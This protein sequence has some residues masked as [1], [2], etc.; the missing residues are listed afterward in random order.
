MNDSKVIKD[1]TVVEKTIPFADIMYD[2]NVLPNITPIGNNILVKGVMVEFKSM[3]LLAKEERGIIADYFEV[4]KIGDMV[5]SKFLN[6][7]IILDSYI[8][9]TKVQKAIPMALNPQRYTTLVEKVRRLSSVDY[10]LFIKTY[11]T[12][13]VIVYF[14]F[15]V[16]NI[17]AIVE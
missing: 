9:S 14:I 6:K 2:F 3:Y 7:K 15:E 12:I 8:D 1:E 5:D 16:S 10:N 4:V 11:P 17:I 13:P